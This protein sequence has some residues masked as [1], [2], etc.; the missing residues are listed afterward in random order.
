MQS[1]NSL[2]SK[3][4]LDHPDLKFNPS[5][6]FSWSHK[7]QAIH[8]V[9]GDNP[10][11]LLH[12]LAHASLGHAGYERDI[13]LLKMERDAWDLAASKLSRRYEVKISDDTV[14]DNLDTYRDWLHSRSTCPNCSSIGYQIKQSE[15]GC[16]ACQVKWR[17][18]EART[19]SLRRYKV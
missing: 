18:N 13:D 1:M 6:D 5:E 12:E 14:Q 16:P 9:E 11:Y 15:Y 2:L 10:E 17:V 19:C 4:K 7:E 8:Y 3:L